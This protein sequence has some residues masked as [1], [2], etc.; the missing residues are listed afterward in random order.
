MDLEA[1]LLRIFTEVFGDGQCV[2]LQ[3]LLVAL[4][5]ER[6]SELEAA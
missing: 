6:E 2:D 1:E 5:L 3:E 4:T